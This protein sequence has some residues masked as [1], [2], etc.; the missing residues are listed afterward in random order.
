MVAALSTAE[1]QSPFHDQAWRFNNLY[2]IQDKRGRTIQFVWNE[3]QEKL[4][5]EARNRDIVLKARQLGF[6]T[7]IDL[8]ALDD[9]VWNDNYSAAIIAHSREDAQRI[10]REKIEFPY[11]SMPDG[12]KNA[13]RQTEDRADEFVFAHGS[14]IRVATS[15]RSG[16]THFLHVSEMGK[17][18]AKFPDKARE[19]KTGSFESVPITGRIFVESTAEGAEGLFFDLCEVA[20]NKAKAH[21]KLTPLDFKFHFYPWWDDPGNVLPEDEGVVSSDHEEYFERLLAHHG[22]LLTPEQKSWYVKKEETLSLGQGSLSPTGQNDMKSEHPS[23]PDEAFEAS[24]EGAYYGKQ[25]GKIRLE[26][27]IGNYPYDPSYPVHTMWDLGLDD[28]MSIAFVQIIGR[29]WIFIDYYENSGEGIEHYV[30]ECGRRRYIYERHYM[31]H[32]SAR[33]SLNSEIRGESVK[34]T[35][36]RLGLRPIKALERT[37]TMEMIV[38]REI[39]MVRRMLAKAHFDERK[40]DR[41][42]K[43]L[44]N[45]RMEWDERRGAFLKRPMHTWASHGADAVRT[46]VVAHTD[47]IDY[48]REQLE[49][50]P[51]PDY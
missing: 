42:I 4:Y 15:A 6:T 14:S 31:P 40:C 24:I 25:M 34:A 10:F 50:E 5:R 17:I 29:A 44:D 20:R 46:G 30:N 8:W 19:V 49:P 39:N 33:R 41:L 2:C 32:D 9:V 43:C 51:E 36:E 47:V 16:T 23:T 26:N 3:A 12:L 45:Y 7:F 48:A 1:D 13:M 22:I 27:R 35:A 28:A 37:K 21:K 18:A 11:N 38:S